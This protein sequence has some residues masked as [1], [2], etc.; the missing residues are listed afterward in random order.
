MTSFASQLTWSE[1]LDIRGRDDLFFCSVKTNPAL[2]A[3]I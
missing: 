3:R 1:K 2:L